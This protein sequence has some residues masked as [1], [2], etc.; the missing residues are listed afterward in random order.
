MLKP[1]CECIKKE[2]ERLKKEHDTDIVN[3]SWLYLG[4]TYRPY[5]KSDGLLSKTWKHSGKDFEYCPFCG[6]KY[7]E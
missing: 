6:K 3:P 4:F 2:V 1:N 5:R 7:K